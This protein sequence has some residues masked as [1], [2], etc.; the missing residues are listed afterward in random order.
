[1]VQVCKTCMLTKLTYLLIFLF[2][3][4]IELGV[5]S[6]LRWYLIPTELSDINFS[7]S[8]IPSRMGLQFRAQIQFVNICMLSA[9]L[10]MIFVASACE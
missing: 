7:L 9:Y 2:A 5:V 3:D 1:M 4:I 8:R 6:F 10:L